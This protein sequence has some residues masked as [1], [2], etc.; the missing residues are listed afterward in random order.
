MCMC[1]YITNFVAVEPNECTWHINE[2]VAFAQNVIYM[3]NDVKKVTK[4]YCCCCKLTHLTIKH[5]KL[6]LVLLTIA[7]LS[8]AKHQVS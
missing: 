5:L 8:S 6:S 1:K 3:T 4:L 7:H 2:V